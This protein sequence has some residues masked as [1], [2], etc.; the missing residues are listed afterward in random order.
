LKFRLINYKT[1]QLSA[2]YLTD[3][4]DLSCG[5]K[6]FIYCCVPN[7]E[8]GITV[9]LKGECHI[10]TEDGWQKQSNVHL[11]GLINKVQLLKMSPNYREISF[12]FYPHY[13][14][15]F[16]KD[17]LHSINKTNGTDLLDL[18][19]KDKVNKLYENLSQCNNDEALMNKIEEF[20]KDNIL[21]AELD[22]RVLVA[23]HLIT[24]ENRYKVDD[25]SKFLNVTPTTLRNLFNQHVGISPKDLIKI[26]RIKK[27]LNYQLTCE[28]SL[29]QMAYHLNYFDQA[30]FCKDFKDSIGISPKQYFINSQLSTDFSDFQHWRY[31]SFGNI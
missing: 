1:K 10:K 9:V 19:K 23:H 17:S 25:L 6:E 20:L 4:Y 26:H 11:Y 24:N 3:V 16:L 29:T 14:Q 27:A 21:I 15:L 31:D 12:G 5:E 30:H 22:K 7:G 28:E 13:L 18:F 8:L 2:K